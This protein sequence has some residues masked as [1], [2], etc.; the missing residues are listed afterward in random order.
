[1]AVKKVLMGNHAVSH[2]VK[3]SRAKVIS[4]YPITPQTHIVEKLSEMCANGELDATFIKVESEHSALATLVGSSSAGVRSFTATSSQGLA[5]MHEVLHWA[6]I[7]RLPI[8]MANVN[9]A[10]APGWNIWT[11]QTDSLAQ[12]D[13]S[14]MQWYCETNQEVLD[15]VIQ[16]FK[17]AERTHFPVMM[18]YDA[19]VLSHTYA[20]VEIP[21]QEK[22]DRY[23]P[24]LQP[25]LHLDSENPMSF[26]ALTPP[27][28]YMELR[29]IAARDMARAL[30]VI[31]EEG[32]LFGEMFGRTYGLVEEYR[33]E[34]AD[35]VLVTAG[36]MTATA[37]E[38]VDTLR[39]KGQ[40]VGLVKLRVFRPFPF[41]QV[42]AVLGKFD[43]IAV[44]DRNVSP[45]LGGIF[46]AEVANALAELSNRPKIY[47]FIAGLGG[48][49]ITPDTFFEIMDLTRTQE[50]KP[51]LTYW[52]GLKGGWH[53]V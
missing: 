33:T 18:V 30:D 42:R 10:M 48:R 26:G 46:A 16:A 40:A 52:V 36:S 28:D 17:V 32:R 3:L 25:G 1:M 39:D 12:R 20:P 9:R 2:G 13:T 7:G 11:E 44:V 6:G 23:L 35:T 50:Y 5:L 19:F 22:V 45:G 51:G 29:Y 49:D 41:E 47:R 21:D 14:W 53:A 38:A 27:E 8:V 43:R 34:G 15:T 31:Q 4:A 37:R 24:P